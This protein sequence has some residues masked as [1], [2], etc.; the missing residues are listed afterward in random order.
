MS[1]FEVDPSKPSN[2]QTFPAM[3]FQDAVSLVAASLGKGSLEKVISQKVIET[4][5]SALR[6]LKYKHPHGTFGKGDNELKRACAMLEYVSREV[7]GFKIP[8]SELAKVAYMKDRDFNKFHQR[9]G[10]FRTIG[11]A[12][13]SALT[14]RSSSRS[15]IPKPTTSVSSIPSLS[16]K[17]GPFV[18][19]SSGVAARAQ[20]LYNDIARYS[21]SNQDQLIDMAR[22]QQIY[23]TACYFLMATQN[24]GA[25]SRKSKNNNDDDDTT[26]PLQLSTVVDLSNN[27]TQ[28]EFQS[29][30]DH[31][32]T[33]QES[34][35]ATRIATELSTN[36]SCVNS[37]T[38]KSTKKNINRGGTASTHMDTVGTSTSRSM[39][40]ALCNTS[41]VEE[42]M[43]PKRIKPL[44]LSAQQL[45]SSTTRD[46][47][48][49]EQEILDLN[50]LQDDPFARYCESGFRS[51]PQLSYSPQF[52]SW[53][54]RVTLQTMQSATAALQA[55]SNGDNRENH[56]V[57]RQQSLKFAAEE[58]LR[59]QG[60]LLSSF[61]TD[62][63]RQAM[64][65]P[66]DNK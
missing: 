35:E 16:I 37:E 38:R 14:P 33:L 9:L 56:A 29:V 49:T 31:I 13:G 10:N 65:S 7:D 21:K 23:E 27:F 66:C 8:M 42:T 3:S 48:Q 41:Q 25:S 60:L 64:S 6:V 19:D 5:Q 53:K 18:T 2:P 40:R 24:M 20:R 15:T 22:N 43:H 12:R 47:L 36:K 39:K 58:F 11:Q 61:Q 46:M 51:T 50:K 32:L 63:W 54:Q 17:L 57:T 52:L 44:I 55:A 62:T 34:M 45:A 59:S 30:L 26:K 1:K 28:A 4:A